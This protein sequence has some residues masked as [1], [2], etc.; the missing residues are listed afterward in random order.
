MYE[1]RSNLMAGNF[2]VDESRVANMIQ[3]AFVADAASMGTHWIYDPEEMASLVPSIEKPEF[4]TPACP[5]YYSSEEFP[6]HY[7]A[8]ML[9]PWGEQLLFATSY[10][11]EHTC[12]TTGHMSV[13]M[14]TW[15][16]SYGGR[17][18]AATKQF[19]VCMKE[20]DRSVELCGADDDQGKRE[21]S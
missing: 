8:G 11:G 9:S 16:E 12:V 21:S 20:G 10:C 15:A 2:M 7:Q 17:Q 3:G 19:L 6:G 18:D 5:K 4:K 14:K 13:K 1:S